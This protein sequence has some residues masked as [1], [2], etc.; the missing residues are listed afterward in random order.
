MI[1]SPY[2]FKLI[3]YKDEIDYLNSE[4]TSLNKDV[5]TLKKKNKNLNSNYKKVNK[6]NKQLLNSS[7]WKITKPLRLIKKF[8][9][10]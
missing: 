3:E 4:I 10:R 7:S 9:S 6:Q 2:S 5:K 1:I 8:F